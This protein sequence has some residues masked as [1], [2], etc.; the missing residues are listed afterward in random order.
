MCRVN[1]KME[2]RDEERGAGGKGREGRNGRVGKG[3]EGLWGRYP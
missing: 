3:R 2:A 1:Q